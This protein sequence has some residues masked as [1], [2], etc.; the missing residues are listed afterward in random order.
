MLQLKSTCSSDMPLTLAILG[1]CICHHFWWSPR[2]LRHYSPRLARVSCIFHSLCAS[3]TDSS[4]YTNQLFHKIPYWTQ[5]HPQYSKNLHHW[6][7]K[8]YTRW[9][10]QYFS[11]SPSCSV[12]T[13]TCIPE[14]C[15]IGLQ[16]FVN[17]IRML[18]SSKLLMI[19]KCTKCIMC[20][21]EFCDKY[22]DDI[23]Y[24]VHFEMFFDKQLLLMIFY[25]M[26][27][28][29]FSVNMNF[30]PCRTRCGGMR[31]QAC[32]LTLWLC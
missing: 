6:M 15:F 2:L 19:H 3:L 10:L 18:S 29:C 7:T 8:F 31:S 5:K 14:L 30:C 16:F 24:N 17:F 9:F 27:L 13:C 1:I 32:L 28:K 11:T 23:Y 20:N 21:F 12:C 22:F 26:H 4:F 25:N